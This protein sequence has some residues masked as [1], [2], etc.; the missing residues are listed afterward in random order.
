[1]KYI[2][3]LNNK[4]YE[5]EVERGKASVISTS[6]I[7]SKETKV[8]SET[9]KSEKMV[10]ATSSV[11]VLRAPMPGTVLDIKVTQG[12]RV[13]EGDIVIILEAMKMENEITATSSG[14][15]S[16]ILVTKGQVVDTNDKLVLIE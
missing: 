1:M 5:V 3:T 4:R 11:K 2:V 10:Q 9:P 16:Q 12:T 15:V 8:A 14:V 13:K 6:E 7:D